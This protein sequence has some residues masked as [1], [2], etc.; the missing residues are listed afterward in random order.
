LL[1]LNEEVNAPPA[2]EPSQDVIDRVRRKREDNFWGG[3]VKEIR[4]EMELSQRELAS[5]AKVNRS[6]LRR[7]EDGQ[8]RGDIDVIEDI[9]AVMGYEID[10]FLSMD[11]PPV[12]VD[13]QK[14][15]VAFLLGGLPR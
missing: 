3:L 12:K 14:E 2:H 7:L 8:A 5:L 4:E 6:T 13:P 11:K 9:L 10:A 15:A 1:D